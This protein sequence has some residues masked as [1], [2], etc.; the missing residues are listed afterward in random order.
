MNMFDYVDKFGN[1]PFSKKAINEVDIFLFAQFSYLNY[2]GIE[3]EKNGRKLKLKEILDAVI[4]RNDYDDGIAHNNALK[5]FKKL[6]NSKRY[7]DL[8]MLEYSYELDDNTQFGAVSFIVPNDRVYISYEGT[9]RS[10]SGWKENFELSYRY[11]THAQ[12][13]ATKFLNRTL[14]R[15]NKQVVVTGH[16]K[17]GNLALVS[18]MRSNLFRKGRIDSIYSFDGPGLKTK[19]FQSFEYRIIKNRLHNIV[20]FRSLVGMLMEQENVCAVNSNAFGIMQHD[21]ATWIVKENGF[22]KRE[23]SSASKSLSNSITRWLKKNDL[24][25]RKRIVE[26]V[27]SI[28]E[29]A[30]IKSLTDIKDNKLKSIYSIAKTSFEFSEET[31]NVILDSI[32]LLIGV[33][34]SDAI[35]E[36]KKEIYSLYE[37]HF[38]R[39][40]K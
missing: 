22:E 27:F 12:I 40:S 3:F 24:E 35:G 39:G 21:P 25:E 15:T 30:G 13:L 9:D 10:I 14:S 20:P 1:E 8:T 4:V 29:K 19:E 17:G 5:L 37:T 33:V 36:K 18:A 2:T 28:V 34:G 26:S 11:P 31:R 32:I 16:S 6:K 38:K 23:L 7:E